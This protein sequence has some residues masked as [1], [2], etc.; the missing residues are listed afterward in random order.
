MDRLVPT[1][2]RLYHIY[3]TLMILVVVECQ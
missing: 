3:K 1:L 2:K